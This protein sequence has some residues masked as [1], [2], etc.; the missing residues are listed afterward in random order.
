MDIEKKL[1]VLHLLDLVEGEIEEETI[2]ESL[3]ACDFTPIEIELILSDLVKTNLIQRHEDRVLL[4]EEGLVVLQFFIDR[5][6]LSLQEKLQEQVVSEGPSSQWDHRYDEQTQRIHLRY[7]HRGE[8]LLNMDFFL[9]PEAYKLLLP[10]LTDL[11][12]EDFS[13]LKMFFLKE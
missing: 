3:V 11:G 10:H 12:P 13:K 7:L 1:C 9:E 2:Q 5:L 8:E 6:P 4:S